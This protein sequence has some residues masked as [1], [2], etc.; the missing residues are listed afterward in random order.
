MHV[1]GRGLADDGCNH[2][3]AQVP[4]KLCRMAA[5]DVWVWYK[6]A[7]VVLR[8]SLSFLPARSTRAMLL[9]ELGENSPRRARV[10]QIRRKRYRS[11]TR[12]SHWRPILQTVL[13]A[14]GAAANLT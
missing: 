1:F 13:P 8:N 9:N 12:G 4:C 6:C 3:C 2:D 5:C 11:L 10:Q 7:S 14:I